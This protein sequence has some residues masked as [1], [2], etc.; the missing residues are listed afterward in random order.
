MT[1]VV[2][3]PTNVTRLLQ[4]AGISPR[5]IQTDAIEAGLLE[6]KSIMVCSP[7]GSGK[8][9]VGE[10][11]LL[12]AIFDGR[13][14]LYLVPLRALAYQVTRLLKKR[15]EEN[16]IRIGVT[17]GD[18]HLTGEEM[19]EYDIIVT[20]YERADSL[21]RHQ[22]PWLPEVGA[23]VIDEVQNIADRSRGARLES[24]IL[25][26]KRSIDDLQIVTLSATVHEPDQL[27]EWLGCKLIQSDERPV[28]LTCRVIS[29]PDRPMAVKRTVMTVVQADGQVLTFHR[30]RREAEAEA[31]RLSENVVRQI[32]GREQ[33]ELDR[34]INSVENSHINIP[35]NLRKL[36]HNGV[37]YH[38]AGLAS[39]VRGL[40]EDMFNSGMVKVVCATTTLA[41]GLDL[42]ARTVVLTSCRSPEN[43]RELLS[44]NSV[45]Q[46]LGRAGRPGRDVKGFGVILTGSRGESDVAKRRYFHEQGDDLTPRYNRVVSRLGTASTLT[47]QTLVLLDLLNEADTERIEEILGESYLLHCAVRN[48]KSPMRLFNLG[49]VTAESTVE[50]HALID[51]VRTA[52]QGALGSV[53]I[54]ETSEEVIGGIVTGFQGGHFTCRFSARLQNSGALEGATCSCGNPVDSMGILCMHLVSLGIAASKDAS[55]R[56]LANY[57]IPIAMEE[58]SPVDRL[59][60]MGLIEG[61]KK[62]GLRITRLG[63]K[64]NR[65]YLSLLTVRE[66][67]A[68]MPFTDDSTKLLSLVRHLVSLEGRQDLDE[69]FEQMIGMVATTSTPVREIADSIGIPVGDAY[70]LL[71]RTR[72]MLFSIQVLAEHGGLEHLTELSGV[73][74]RGI[75]ERLDNRGRN[76]DGSD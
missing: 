71:D 28:P 38:H 26:L 5:G 73:L 21:L 57:V 50:K 13:R 55:F 53:S 46:M 31:L 16:V 7:T 45:H 52:R 20:T 70:S 30:T 76:D 27:A 19:S 12:R 22:A 44:A 64:V 37:A 66:M 11:A 18:M 34:E 61:G 48:P 24:V 15:Y 72:W 6:G 60:R 63:R 36:L 40:V 10:M 65:L 56:E 1:S 41:T 33:R 68:M 17:T 42:P 4:Q 9:L 8:T 14:G 51:T 54:R 3:V 62:V 49:V 67:M 32:G 74:L 75:N 23:V 47:E 29:T 59:T 43:Y 39:K 35:P 2:D 58:S 69:S 25:R